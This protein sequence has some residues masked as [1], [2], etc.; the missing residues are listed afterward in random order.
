MSYLGQRRAQVLLASF[1]LVSLAFIAVP[2]VD[3]RFSA[4]FFDG[5]FPAARSL[6]TRFLHEGL[7][8][9][10]ATIVAGLIAVP[11]LNRIRKRNVLGM[12]ART[13]IYLLIVLVVGNGL[14]VNVALKDH[15]GRARPRDVTQ[16]G[17]THR[18]TP[19]F[20]LSDQ[21]N[22]NCSFSSGEA[23]GGFFLIALAKALTR[24]RSAVILATGL[25]V[26]IAAARVA[27]GA[28]FLSDA[29]VSFFIM[30]LVSDVTYHYLVL[31]R[32]PASTATLDP[33]PS[34]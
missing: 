29:V 28:H 26:I 15:V 24:R 8:W 14:I 19:A 11:V 16:F 22:R 1:A 31:R 12:N 20:V 21:C 7:T 18:F 17:G 10:L 13:T 2:A 23:A 27:A 33:A 4:L 9:V 6:W 5:T 3:L 30:L 25:G 32:R 34:S